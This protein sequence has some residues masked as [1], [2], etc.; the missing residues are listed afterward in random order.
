MSRRISILRKLMPVVFAAVC[1]AACAQDHGADTTSLAGQSSLVAANTHVDAFSQ[2]TTATSL[3]HIVNGRS[4]FINTNARV[5]RIFVSNPDVLN[6]YTVDTHQVII[7]AKATGV[8]TLI[9]WDEFGHSQSYQVSSDLD[10][11]DLSGA[12]HNAFPLDDVHVYGSESRAVLTGSVD[13]QAASDAVAKLA[14]IYTKDVSDALVVDPTRIKQVRLK[15]RI[16]EIDR[17]KLTQFG[18]NFFSQGGTNIAGSTTGQF[19]STASVAAPT[20]IPGSSSLFQ[21]LTVSDPLNFLFYS[22]KYNI[23][24]TVQDL[25]NKNILQILAEPNITT[26]SGQKADFLAGG[27][28]PFPVIQGGVGAATSVTIQFRQY[29]VKL[30]FLPIV[31]ADGTIEL[32]VAPEV[33]A[34]DFSNAV[35]ISG[36]TIPALSTR[37]AETQVNLRSGES[38]AIGGLLD[39]RTTDLYG[40]TP[41]FSSIP[42]LGQL[43][44]SR[45]VNHT[46]TDLVVIVT[47]E[48]VDPVHDNTAPVEPVLP[49]PQLDPKPF[50]L[51]LPKGAVTPAA[52][53]SPV[54]AGLPTVTLA[55]SSV[56]Q[57]AAVPTQAD[58]DLLLSGLKQ[59]GYAV[60]ASPDPQ[61]GLIRIQAG[62][63]ANRKDADAMQQ[64]LLGDGYNAVVID[65]TVAKKS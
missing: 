58:A 11:D 12:I 5:S 6:S 29:G 1:I 48:I 59:R 50:D 20:A 15:V 22:S 30:E 10:V 39:Q 44:K 2:Q 53:G 49:V 17:A 37:R 28:F 33:S 31:N 34:L 19:P 61:G 7:T 42:I 26:L 51:S 13:T 57:V 27:E 62:P 65:A 55:Q 14:A 43:F 16:V 35:S 25:Q 21:Q 23:G 47:P 52:A 18:V 36:Y 8:S 40:S 32:T 9:I 60:S 4:I 45:S 54:A 46:N 56:V 64:R 3:L 41:G 24:A 38:F 63:F